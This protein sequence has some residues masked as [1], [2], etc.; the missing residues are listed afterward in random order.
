V[1]K[2]INHD[3]VNPRPISPVTPANGLM[4]CFSADNKSLLATAWDQ[5]QHLFQGVIVCIHSDPHLGGLNPHETKKLRG[6]IYLM[7]N[8]PSK[9]LE[10]YRR[11]FPEQK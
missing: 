6:K 4:G 11:D 8:E 2:G 10:A 7:A 1:P 9:L 3:D 5:T